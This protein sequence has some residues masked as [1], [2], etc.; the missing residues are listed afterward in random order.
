LVILEVMLNGIVS[1]LMTVPTIEPKSVQTGANEGLPCELDGTCSVDFRFRWDERVDRFDARASIRFFGIPVEN[2]HMGGVVSCGPFPDPEFATDRFPLAEQEGFG[3]FE[4]N[5]FDALFFFSTRRPGDFCTLTLDIR[6]YVNYGSTVSLE[7]GTV[8]DFDQ[9]PTDPLPP[10]S[11]PPPGEPGTNCPV[12]RRSSSGVVQSQAA[13]PDNSPLTPQF[14]LG[15]TATDG[16][17]AD[18]TEELF[19]ACVQTGRIAT[20]RWTAFQTPRDGSMAPWGQPYESPANPVRIHGLWYH[21][22]QDPACGQGTLRSDAALRNAKYLMRVEALSDGGSTIATVDKPFVATTPW[23]FE[24]ARSVIVSFTNAAGNIVEERSAGKAPGPRVAWKIPYRL[25]PDGL[26]PYLD[27]VTVEHGVNPPG[28][29]E[30]GKGLLA[31][32]SQFRSKIIGHEEEHVKYNKQRAREL[33]PKAT[34][35]SAL[36]QCI[37]RGDCVNPNQALL[38]AKI[39]PIVKSWLEFS[40]CRVKMASEDAAYA[41]SDTVGPPYI[42]QKCAVENELTE[43]RQKCEKGEYK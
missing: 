20:F 3:S 5:F 38:E 11:E 18:G 23:G 6:Y 2:V 13:T 17:V 42:Y 9:K 24:P 10:G 1:K 25:L 32:T 37:D 35:I 31:S 43:F 30:Y 14:E 27:G 21:D 8:E 34:L 26:I 29:P 33:W 28:V 12:P 16:R 39:D 22:A 4:Y 19:S 15:F 40:P 36:R 41:K 7:I